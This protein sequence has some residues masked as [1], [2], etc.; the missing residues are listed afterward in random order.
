MQTHRVSDTIQSVI[1]ELLKTRGAIYK[2]DSLVLGA[3]QPL[4][5]PVSELEPTHL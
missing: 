4:R 2:T 5:V 3:A 1:C